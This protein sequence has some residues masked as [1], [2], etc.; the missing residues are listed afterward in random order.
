MS[1]CLEERR[2]VIRGFPRMYARR[3]WIHMGQ[4]RSKPNRGYECINSELER[5]QV[6][7]VSSLNPPCFRV[8]K[9][10]NIKVNGVSIVNKLGI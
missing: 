7:V 10:K 4:I 2:T 6:F 9:S 5:K 3:A 1:V 8:Y